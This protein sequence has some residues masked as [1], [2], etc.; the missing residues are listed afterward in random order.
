MRVAAIIIG[1]WLLV[2]FYGYCLHVLLHSDRLRWLSQR[3][4]AH[5][6]HLDGYPPGRR[7]RS[8]QYRH[9]SD[10]YFRIAG[11]GLEW[12]AP[13]IILIA[14]TALGEWAIGLT[15]LEILASE[16]ILISYSIFLFG[17]L[18]DQMHVK[19]NWLLRSTFFRRWFLKAR[20]NHDIHHNH[21][22][23]QGL[24]GKNFGIAFPL[25]DHLFGTYHHRLEGLNK[26]GVEAA[27][28]RYD[29]SRKK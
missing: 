11:V 21:I 9:V 27:Y 17:Y 3:H 26:Y 5:H 10:N 24:M 6:L 28:D 25:Y 12:L 1:S 19:N 20:R 7:M 18:H 4:M 23:D 2:E 22:T 13:A 29:I 15:W 8:N 16:I 14:V